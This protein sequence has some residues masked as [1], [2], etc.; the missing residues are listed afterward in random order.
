VVGGVA[1]EVGESA[2]VAPETQVRHCR[3]TQTSPRRRD[4]GAAACRLVGF[5]VVWAGMSNG[6]TSAQYGL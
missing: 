1:V 2:M 3:M 5:G 4:G 6:S